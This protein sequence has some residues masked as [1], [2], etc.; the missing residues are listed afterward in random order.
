[1]SPHATTPLLRSPL[2]KMLLLLRMRSLSVQLG[3]SPLTST[4]HTSYESQSA[5]GD[6]NLN[7]ELEQKEIQ[8]HDEN[9]QG[10][11]ENVKG[12]VQ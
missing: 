2:G 10:N 12:D 11:D 1:M 6:I 3:T 5:I 8:G 4:T 7:V 9:V